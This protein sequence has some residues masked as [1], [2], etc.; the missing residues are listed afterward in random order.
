M[1]ANF[2][3]YLRPNGRKKLVTFE[4][5]NDLKDQLDA[6]DAAG[7]RLTAEVLTTGQV[8]FMIEH[9]K[10]GDFDGRIVAN[11]PGVPGAVNGLIRRFDRLAFRSWLAEHEEK[12]WLAIK[13]TRGGVQ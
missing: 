9:P 1:I 3:Q 11:G 8:S 6:I 10:H 13:A 7:M 2:V 12:D 5:D 4:V